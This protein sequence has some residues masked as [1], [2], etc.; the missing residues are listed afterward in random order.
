MEISVYLRYR[1]AQ[2]TLV[3]KRSEL[4]ISVHVTYSYG[5]IVSDGAGG[6]V[7]RVWEYI[8]K[9]MSGGKIALFTR[10]DV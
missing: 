10:T 6:M 8:F 5:Y 2:S 1:R 9:I 3:E 4:F 7:Y